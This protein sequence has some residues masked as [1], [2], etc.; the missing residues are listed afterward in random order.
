MLLNQNQKIYIQIFILSLAI[1]LIDIFTPLGVAPG[2]GYIGA[3]ILSLKLEKQRDLKL[4]LIITILLVI[5]GYFLSQEASELWVGEAN[6]ILTLFAL[7]STG[8]IAIRVKKIEKELNKSIDMPSEN[9]NPIMRI[10]HD[11]TIL[12][13]NQSAQKLFQCIENQSA[14]KYL[15]AN[16]KKEI[17]SIVSS[18]KAMELEFAYSGKTISFYFT[19]IS[20]KNYINLYGTDITVRK[21]S[22]KLLHKLSS[23]DELTGIFNR[24]A[25]NQ[26]IESEIKRAV[27]FKTKLSVIMM[28]VD[29]FKKYNDAYGHTA[30][31]SVLIKI[32]QK[33]KKTC[34]RPG[35]IVARYGGEE[36]IVLLPSTDLEGASLLAEKIRTSIEEAK[37]KHQ[38]S[39]ISKYVT[40]SLGIGTFT[41]GKS[42][43]AKNLIKIA[44]DALYKAK[45]A[46]RNGASTAIKSF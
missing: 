46:G 14:D 16:W 27:R 38:K 3:I 34:N 2:I 21:K 29:F 30:G 24:R 39:Y 6:R 19:P 25:F 44:D 12:Y 22:E 45:L 35:D 28:D 32:A 7:G 10:S 23:T 15:P 5:S 36:F 31:D 42:V 9:P 1:F 11:Y 43:P 26:S 8:Y 20:N 13:A 40:V 33:L 41:L 17:Q 37:I 4:T 18:G